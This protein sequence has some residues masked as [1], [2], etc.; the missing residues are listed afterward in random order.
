[1]ENSEQWGICW[2]HQRSSK[3][4][5]RLAEGHR[6]VLV[7]SLC[8][9]SQKKQL[10]LILGRLTKPDRGWEW[11][12][13]AGWMNLN[14]PPCELCAIRAVYLLKIGQWP[15]SWN[16]KPAQLRSAL[17][18]PRLTALPS[19]PEGL[20]A[21]PNHTQNLTQCWNALKGHTW[22]LL[23]FCIYKQPSST[24]RCLYFQTYTFFT[25]WD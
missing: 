2:D 7:R 16:P 22:K 18:A 8:P 10:L 12:P 9:G 11:T 24:K 23:A 25:L 6:Q 17:P 19:W 4:A 20:P 15:H 14:Q 13:C 3:L 5:W 21:L 1:M